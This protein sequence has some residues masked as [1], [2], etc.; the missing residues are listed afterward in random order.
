MKQKK[1]EIQSEKMIFN[2]FFQ[3]KEAYLRFELFTGQMS[4]IIHR[5]N[6][7]RGNSVAA[8][9][10]DTDIQKFVFTNQFRYP[11]YEKGPG[12][13]Y[14]IIAGSID[15]QEKPDDAIRR[16]ILEEIGYDVSQSPIKYISNFYVSPG[17]TSERI[18][19]YYIEVNQDNKVAVGGGVETEDI[20]IVEMSL[21][22]TYNVLEK[23][24][25]V[26]AKTLI[27]LLW[28]KDQQKKNEIRSS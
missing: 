18:Y 3:I 12:W 10:Y 5:L 22:D 27:A 20:Q 9:V 8:L 13:I 23:G 14:E 4:E 16:E 15:P 7:V 19:L 28:L 2:N 25:I 26:D 11:T 21:I 24:L 1:V 6:F 17:G